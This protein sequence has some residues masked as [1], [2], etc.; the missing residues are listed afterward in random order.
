MLRLLLKMDSLI[1]SLDPMLLLKL[2]MHGRRFDPT[3]RFLVFVVVLR[4]HIGGAGDRWLQNGLD[5]F[6]SAALC[7]IGV[8]VVIPAATALAEP[9]LRAAREKAEAFFRV[10]VSS[11][12]G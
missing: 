9:I 1:G 3:G 12:L 5:A 10:V 7:A 6:G 2:E 8:F 4:F 11:L